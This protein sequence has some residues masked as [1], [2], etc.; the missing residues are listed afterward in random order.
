MRACELS[1]SVETVR[2]LRGRTQRVNAAS[3]KLSKDLIGNLE[4]WTRMQAD[5]MAK[6]VSQIKFTIDLVEQD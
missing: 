3:S 1:K 2:E 5:E 6:L 4:N